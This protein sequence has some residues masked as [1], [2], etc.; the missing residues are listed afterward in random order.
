MDLKIRIH[1]QTIVLDPPI[2][3]SRAF[4]YKL[5]HDTIEVIC[6]LQRVE[7][8]RYDKFKEVENTKDK[9]YKTLVID[10]NSRELN[11][12]YQVLEKHIRGA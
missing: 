12:A 4:L 7:A 3:E 9:T 1:D 2:A 8:T 5:F 10:M 11:N 6:G